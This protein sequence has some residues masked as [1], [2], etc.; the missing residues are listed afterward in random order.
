M[1]FDTVVDVK[2]KQKLK[3]ALHLLGVEQSSGVVPSQSNT[4]QQLPGVPA[5]PAQIVQR[6]ADIA[7]LRQPLPE[8][9]YEK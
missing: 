1:A 7:E 8:G 6:E 3:S 9:L 5:L 2:T 4:N